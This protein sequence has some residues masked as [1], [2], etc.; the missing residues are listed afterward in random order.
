MELFNVSPYLLLL[1]RADNDIE[2]LNNAG[3]D[4]IRHVYELQQAEKDTLGI[5]F[6]L[7]FIYYRLVVLREHYR[8]NGQVNLPCYP[9]VIGAIFYVRST[10]NRLDGN[11]EETAGALPCTGD[12]PPV[13][14]TEDIINLIELLYGCHELKMFNDGNITL[15]RLVEY[16]C[17][18]FGVDVKNAS[19]YYA[20]MRRR[21]ADE[22]T[23]F[24]DRLREALL[25]RMEDDDEKHY[26][27][28][29]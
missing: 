17:G 1:E 2:R 11:K 13:Y 19:S 22:R 23:Y 10:M 3:N 18:M 21:K 7:Q 29:R 8:T 9:H 27:R 4:F 16:V 24:I 26:S 15:K 5:F 20:R 14:W 28:N 6:H 12:N 25:K